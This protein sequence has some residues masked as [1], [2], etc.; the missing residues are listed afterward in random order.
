MD[1]ADGSFSRPISATN[2]A[3]HEEVAFIVLGRLFER[4]VRAEAGFH[5]VF[6]RRIRGEQVTRAALTPRFYRGRV[7]FIELVNVLDNGGKLRGKRFRFFRRQFKIGQLCDL[8]DFWFRDRH[9]AK[10]KDEG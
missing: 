3:R 5:R 6:P 7:E 1:G 4:L 2:D 9:L 10:M 8:F